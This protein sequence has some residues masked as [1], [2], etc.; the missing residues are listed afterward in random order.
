MTV[1]TIVVYH[2]LL[3]EKL[4]KICKFLKIKY[5]LSGKIVKGTN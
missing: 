1:E 4:L 5:Y 3:L 2:N